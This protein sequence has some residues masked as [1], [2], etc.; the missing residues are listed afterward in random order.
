MSGLGLL[1]PETRMTPSEGLWAAC[2]GA[3]LVWL[4]V[5]PRLALAPSFFQSPPRAGAAPH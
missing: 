1:S 3:S 4:G 5:C 2:V